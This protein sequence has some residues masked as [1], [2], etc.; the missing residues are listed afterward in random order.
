MCMQNSRPDARQK[1]LKSS[2]VCLAGENIARLVGEE[3]GLV[4]YHCMSN[5]REEHASAPWITDGQ[6]GSLGAHCVMV[7]DDSQC[8][9]DTLKVCDTFGDALL[10]WHNV[11]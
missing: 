6:V 5:D 11:T 1:L 9:S 2:R 7:Q 4:V 8:L 10:S 3:D